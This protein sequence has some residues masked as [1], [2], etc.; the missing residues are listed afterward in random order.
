MSLR[1][2]GSRR[3]PARGAC[4]APTERP[5]DR[6]G[7]EKRKDGQGEPTGRLSQPVHEGEERDGQ[8]EDEDGGGQAAHW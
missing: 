8:A 7:A 5:D 6:Q 3:R 4:A 1:P 2:V